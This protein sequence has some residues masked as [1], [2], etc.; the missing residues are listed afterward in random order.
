VKEAVF[1]RQNPIILG[2]T[3]KA[4]MLKIGTPLCIPEKEN[5]RI[6]VV[7]SIELNKKSV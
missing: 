3:V 2:V 1:N 5:L 4:G 7:E 6:G